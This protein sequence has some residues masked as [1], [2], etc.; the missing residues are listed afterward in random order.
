[1]SYELSEKRSPTYLLPIA[2]ADAKPIP[3][4]REPVYAVFV[5]VN[6]NPIDIGGGG[7]G[8]VAWADI[9]GKPSTFTPTIGST[10][11]TAAAGNHVHAVAAITGL[12]T[13]LDAKLTA[14]KAATQAASTATDVVGVV[15]DLNALITKLKTAGIMA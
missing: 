9:T 13:A 2:A 8:P 6:G 3:E 11:T 5:D 7:S 10:A 4:K 14:A 12:Q 1:M 15:A